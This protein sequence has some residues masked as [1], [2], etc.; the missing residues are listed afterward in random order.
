MEKLQAIEYRMIGL[1]RKLLDYVDS[2][3]VTPGPFAV[4]R[5]KALNYQIEICFLINY[6]S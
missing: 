3:Y 2:I 4:Y 5:K 1:T 6:S